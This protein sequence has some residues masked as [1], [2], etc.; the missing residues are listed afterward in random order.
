VSNSRTQKPR[1]KDSKGSPAGAAPGIPEKPNET[2]SGETPWSGHEVRQSFNGIDSV[3]Y[4]TRAAHFVGLWESERILFDRYLPGREGRVL[5]AGCGAGRVTMGLWGRGY[6][7]I[8]AFD[9]AEELLDQARSLAASLGAEGVD[10]RH[11][12]ATK[13]ER[14]GL[15]LPEGML[16]DAALFMFNGLMQIPRRQCRREAL[17]HI[18]PLL[19]QGAPILFT[20]HDRD[21][22]ETE[23]EHW[24]VEAERWAAGRQDPRLTDF[25]DRLFRDESGEVFIHIPDRREIIEDLEATGWDPVFD[26]MRSELSRETRAVT[27]FSD[28]CRFWVARRKS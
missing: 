27:E 15:A 12:D 18:G 5:E 6:R 14:S 23:R 3:L 16:F 20:S 7:N 4:Y 13:L 24:R 28:D 2:G 9:F 10:F 19:R 21:A 26:C 17:G 8:T 25:G 11:A 1:A 22:S